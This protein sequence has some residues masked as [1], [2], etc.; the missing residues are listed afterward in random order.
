MREYVRERMRSEGAFRAFEA[1]APAYD[2]FTV[3]EDQQSWLAGLLHHL[4]RHGR[5]GNRLLDVACGTGK[6]LI[7]MLAREWRVSGY[8]I[9]PG[10]LALARQKVGTEA[11]LHLADMRKQP[12]LGYFDVVWAVNDVMNYLLSP[13]S[14]TDALRGMRRNLAIGGLLAFD[15]NTLLVYRTV[16]AKGRIVRTS[17]PALIWTGFARTNEPPGCECEAL[18]EVEGWGTDFSMAHRQR[19]FP[20]ATARGCIAEA[21]LECLEVFGRDDDGALVQPLDESRHRKAVYLTRD[22]E[23]AWGRF[24]AKAPGPT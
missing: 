7:P 24:G 11:T 6:S 23:S 9:S 19:H 5:I 8:D 2:V 12:H 22:R 20:E 4:N 18:F 21:G 14:L 16:F 15:L 3:R 1:M 17:G 10:M 13:W